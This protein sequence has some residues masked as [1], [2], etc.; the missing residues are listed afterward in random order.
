MKHNQFEPN[1]VP[2]GIPLELS[3][4][5]DII[6]WAS[7]KLRWVSNCPDGRLKDGII[8]SLNSLL[9]CSPLENVEELKKRIGDLEFQVRSFERIPKNAMPASEE[10]SPDS[11]VMLK[12]VAVGFIAC[13]LL[14][15]LLTRL[16]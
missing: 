7:A 13:F 15:L 5:I 14:Q 3:N 8:H 4:N 11:R 12:G 2:K 6:G 10:S 1:A 16:I 9:Q